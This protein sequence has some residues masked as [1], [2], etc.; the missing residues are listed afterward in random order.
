MKME[1]QSEEAKAM[2][3]NVK[4][5]SNVKHLVGKDEITLILDPS[6]KYTIKDVLQEITQSENKELSTMLIEVEGKT[7]G[8]VRVVVNGEE[9]QSLNGVETIIQDGDRITIFPL[10]AGG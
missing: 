1:Q 4:F 9:I 10:L 5:F 7:R 8:A 3:V 6:R 2:A